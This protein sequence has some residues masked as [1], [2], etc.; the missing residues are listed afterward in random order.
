[1]IGSFILLATLGC[2]NGV[3][4]RIYLLKDQTN[5]DQAKSLLDR[6][7]TGS[8]LGSESSSFDGL[9]AKIKEES[10][11]Q[12]SI[13][14]EAFK[15]IKANPK[16]RASIAKKALEQLPKETAAPAEE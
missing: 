4:E 12:A 13:F 15:G 10:P 1:M 16:N 9:I 14:E 8:P 5:A 11:E 7:T 6:Y 3:E 2:G